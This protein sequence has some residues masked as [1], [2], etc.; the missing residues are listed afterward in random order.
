M[1]Y[2]RIDASRLML[3]CRVIEKNPSGNAG[4]SYPPPLRAFGGCIELCRFLQNGIQH[5]GG[6]WGNVAN[7]LFNPVLS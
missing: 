1:R 7:R 5:V 4:L 3:A 6:W 2:G